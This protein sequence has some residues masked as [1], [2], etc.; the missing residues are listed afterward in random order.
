MRVVR[1]HR[2]LRERVADMWEYRELLVG[3][4]RKDLKVRYKSSALGFAWSLVNP[5]LYLV[6]FYVAFQVVLKAGI[7]QFPIWLLSGLLV[8]NLFSVG[9]TAATGSVTANAEIVKKVAFPREILPLAAVGAA[10][11]HFLLQASVLAVALLAYRHDVAWGYLPLLP[12]GLFA[13]LVFAAGLGMLL[14][15]INV[16]LRDTE[17]FVELALLAWFWFTPIIYPYMTVGN[18][19]AE[20][21][22]LV[23]LYTANP[24]TPIVVTFQRTIYNRL[25]SSSP[26]GGRLGEI[27]AGTELLPGWGVEAY[28]L[29]LLYTITLGVILLFI[30]LWAFARYEGDFAEEL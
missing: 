27:G 4:I 10:L 15:A 3:L 22:F 29:L 21:G 13:V 12:L 5:L 1:A 9:L 14:A 8:W 25:E 24:I 20:N 6:I 19:R 7:P 18:Q 28:L 30:G 17:H 11:V 16:R 2:T 23:G 26:G